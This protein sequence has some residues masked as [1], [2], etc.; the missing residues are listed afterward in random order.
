M[1]NQSFSIK[2]QWRL[3]GGSYEWEAF[4]VLQLVLRSEGQI[5]RG[6]KRRSG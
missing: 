6:E 1:R 5:T 3:C 2:G 4:T